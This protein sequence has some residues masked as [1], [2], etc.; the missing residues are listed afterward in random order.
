MSEYVNNNTHI[1][2]KHNK[3]GHIYYVKP[4]A[5]LSKNICP[6]Y[7]SRKGES[8]IIKF[9]NRYMINY[10]HN[11]PYGN[12]SYKIIDNWIIIHLPILLF[13]LSY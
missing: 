8:Y 6:K 1:T 4:N 7:N 2:M 11:K 3:C 10:E 9:L 12:C 5:F 13:Q